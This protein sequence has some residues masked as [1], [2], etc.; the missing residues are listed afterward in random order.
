MESGEWRV[1]SGQ[2]A[3]HGHGEAVPVAVVVGNALADGEAGVAARHVAPLDGAP[4]PLHQRPVLHLGH[5]GEELVGVH[6]QAAAQSA[7]CHGAAGQGV[8][9]VGPHHVGPLAQHRAAEAAV[10]LGIEAP[11]APVA[12]RHAHQAP[13]GLDLGA[14]RQ[15]PAHHHHLATGLLQRPGMA[16]HATVVAQ[17]VAYGHGHFY[18]V[19]FIQNCIITL[20]HPKSYTVPQKNFSTPPPH[21]LPDARARPQLPFPSPSGGLVVL[22]LYYCCTIVVLLKT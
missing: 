12:Q 13:R 10:E 2:V 22:S 19:L 7:C 17:V 11:A 15:A 1:G 18:G 21:P 6:H 3:H 9:V 16:R 20:P 5:L 14:R 8:G 4:H